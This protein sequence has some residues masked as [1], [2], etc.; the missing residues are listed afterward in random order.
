VGRGPQRSRHAVHAHHA[1]TP[2]AQYPAY[3]IARI[4]E[5]K[6]PRAAR[7]GGGTQAAR[8]RA[9]RPRARRCHE[10]D[11][12]RAGTLP[13]SAA[14]GHRKPDRRPGPRN[15]PRRPLYR[16]APPAAR[17]R[18]WHA[19]SARVSGRFR[20]GPPGV[21]IHLEPGCVPASGGAQ[22]P[23]TAASR[24]RVGRSKP[25][26]P[27]I[28]AGRSAFGGMHDCGADRTSVLGPGAHHQSTLKPA[29][30]L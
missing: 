23:G 14:A 30:A 1:N 12:R 4:I 19:R 29:D 25:G 9:G 16:R 26:G 28:A 7:L 15:V 8:G 5:T 3:R 17:H 20:A 10:A 11:G 27:G 6:L 21:S 22:L 13:G 24:E 2:L 18:T